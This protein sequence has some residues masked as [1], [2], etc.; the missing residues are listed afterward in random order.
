MIG[1]IS[2]HR[3]NEI[4]RESSLTLSECDRHIIH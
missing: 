1:E 4:Q 3:S 2:F